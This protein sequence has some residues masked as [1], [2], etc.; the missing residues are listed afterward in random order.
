G[1]PW[2]IKFVRMFDQTNDAEHFRTAQSLQDDG[3]HLEGNRWVRRK[4]IYLPLYE[5][6]M[7][8]AFDHRAASV[9][10]EGA[11]WM[12][13]GQTE[14]TT[15]V[16]HQNP[17][18]CAAPRFWVAQTDVLE[19]RGG[20]DREAFLAM[21]D[22]TSPTNQRT[23]I[24]SFIPWSAVV[25]SAPLIVTTNG[26]DSRKGCCLLANLNSFAYDFIA[27]QKVGGLHLN[28]FIVEQLPTLPPDRYDEKC[29][30]DKKQT[31]EKWI[32]E[33]VLK[34]TCTANDM[35]PL[36][37]AAGFKEGVHKWNEA[38][39]QKLRAELDA[40]Y[41]HLY[42]LARDEVDYV[43]DQFQGVVKQDEAHGRPG[44]IRSA[45]LEAYDA[46]QA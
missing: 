23:M 9:I 14:E 17:E 25:N 41:F 19:R 18:F 4:E 22:V 8:Q 33:R 29:P 46:L 28:F 32:S 35:R 15:L 45:I 37:E 16:M 44:P 24:A 31:L 20:E 5:A 2:A 7:I 26:I 6:K 3:F 36:A 1:N 11:N 30:W 34:L 42:G 21:K 13:Q 12:R 27:R 38:E 43:L 10:V 40:A 39:R